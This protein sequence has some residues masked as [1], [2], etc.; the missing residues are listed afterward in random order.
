MRSKSPLAIFVFIISCIGIVASFFMK[1]AIVFNCI[2]L[3]IVGMTTLH[4]IGI[5]KHIDYI[6]LKEPNGMIASVICDETYSSII[7][8]TS[9]DISLPSQCYYDSQRLVISNHLPPIATVGQTVLLSISIVGLIVSLIVRS[10][11]KNNKSQRSM[12]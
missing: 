2:P 4:H 3:E 1:Y 5:N 8:C 10:G 11:N 9:Y 6:K 7:P 12:V